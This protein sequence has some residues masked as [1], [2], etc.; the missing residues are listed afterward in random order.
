MSAI[1][2]VSRTAALLAVA[3]VLLAGTGAPGV[4]TAA[5]SAVVGSAGGDADP[6]LAAEDGPL[7]DPYRPQ[8]WHLDRLGL[9]GTRETPTG[10]GIVVA[11]VDSGI[12]L[13]HPDLADAILRDTSGE[14]VGYDWIDDDTVPADEFGHGTMVAGVLAAAAGNGVGGVGVAP[15]AKLMPLR[16]LDDAGQ[17]PTSTIAE[18][19]HFAV[20][21]GADVVNLSLEAATAIGVDRIPAVIT[22]IE[23]AVAADVVVVASAGN[24]GEP[25]SDFAPELGVVVVGATDRDDSRAGFS[26]GGRVDLLMAP[27][28]DI[29]STWCRPAESMTCDGITHNQG[30]ADG[31]SFAAP[32]VAGLVALLRG[33]GLSGAESVARLRATTVDI[34][35]PGPDP[36]TGMGLVTATAAL[37]GWP[38][39]LDAARPPVVDEEPSP[40]AVDVI[41]AVS[42][43]EQIVEATAPRPFRVMAWILVAT[44]ALAIAIITRGIAAQ[45]RVRP[46]G[47]MPDLGTGAAGSAP[48]PRPPVVV[49]PGGRDRGPTD[50]RED[51]SGDQ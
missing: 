22:A 3:L 1:P 36:E 29:V 46:V 9:D 10:A 8:Q 18:A 35:E 41:P 15:D 13:E 14:V 27:G 7:A 47:T 40:A 26:D 2:V 23:R 11:I 45:R 37:R 51:D 33:A 5:F 44:I 48:A 20:D 19:I 43:P 49:M 30:I 50:G 24:R 32:Q 42:Q 38:G 34:G 21:N 28:V 25:L 16:V 39:P 12:D 31:T 4:V 17:G 6:A